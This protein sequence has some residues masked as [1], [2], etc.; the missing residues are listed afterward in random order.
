MTQTRNAARTLLILAALCA[1]ALALDV[2]GIE[3]AIAP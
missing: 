1:L 3:R 2:C